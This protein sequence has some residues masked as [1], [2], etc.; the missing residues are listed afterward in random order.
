MSKKIWEVEKFIELIDIIHS[1][2]SDY[3]ILLSGAGNNDIKMAQTIIN[4]VAKKKRIYNLVNKTSIIDLISIISK[5]KFVVGN[6]SA[7]VH[8]AAATHVPSICIFHGAHYGRFLPYP[9]HLP[10]IEYHPHAI[11]V[12]MPC[13]GCGYKCTQQERDNYECLHRVTVDMVRESLKYVI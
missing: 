2:H 11:F 1:I 5:A 9:N 7:A 13:F 8:I 10:N 12:K 3:N 4:G 6:D